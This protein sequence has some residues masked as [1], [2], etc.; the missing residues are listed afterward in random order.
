MFLFPGFL[1]FHKQLVFHTV[2]QRLPGSLDDIFRNADVI[3]LPYKR[4]DR[5]IDPPLILLEAM[6]SLCIPLTRPAG[7]VPEVVPSQWLCDSEDFVSWAEEKINYLADNL[8]EARNELAAW[9]DRNG[10]RA[11][12]AAATFLQMIRQE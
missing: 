4:F 11:S 2:H 7:A 8:T 12:E 10:V 6:A 1:F 5:T 3:V 9:N